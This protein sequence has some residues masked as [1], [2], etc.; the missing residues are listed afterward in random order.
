MLEISARLLGY[1]PPKAVTGYQESKFVFH[2]TLIW[3]LK[4]GWKGFEGGGDVRINSLGF[5]TDEISRKSPM[6]KRI[7]C[8]GDSVTFGYWVNQDEPWPQ[9]LQK[10]YQNR[11]INATVINAGVPGYS[12][13][14]SLEQWRLKGKN[15]QPDVVILGYCLNDATER[16]SKVASYGGDDIFLGVDTS[17]A[18][19]SIQ[20]LLRRSALYRYIKLKLQKSAK[21]EETYSV[22]RLFDDPLAPPI[23]GA[24]ERNSQEIIALKDEIEREGKKLLVVIFPYFFQFFLKENGEVHNRRILSFCEKNK[25]DCIDLFPVFAS[26]LKDNLFLDGNHFTPAGHRLVANTIFEFL[27]HPR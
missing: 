21:L 1:A 23:K 8:L 18:L 20:R 13:F 15:L 5:R 9:V 27:E 24:W 11:G 4:A 3:E 2:P 26:H 12:T 6:E 17:Q 14:Q 7:L 10:M 22:R 25:I 19:P 16:Y